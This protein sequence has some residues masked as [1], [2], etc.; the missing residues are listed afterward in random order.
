MIDY[1]QLRTPPL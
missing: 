1:L